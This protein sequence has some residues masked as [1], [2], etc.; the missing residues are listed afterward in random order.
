MEEVAGQELIDGRESQIS[1][2]E[3]IVLLTSNLETAVADI[4]RV[5]SMIDSILDPT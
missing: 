1:L 5:I 2:K 4:A 3:T